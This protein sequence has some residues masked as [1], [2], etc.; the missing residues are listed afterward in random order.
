VSSLPVERPV[1]R[2]PVLLG[3]AAALMFAFAVLTLAVVNVGGA[4]LPG[5]VAFTRGLQR[6]I[7]AG[8]PAGV[9]LGLAGDAIWFLPALAA[10]ATLLARGWRAAVFLIVAGISGYLI[11]EHLLTNIVARPRPSPDLVAIYGPGDGYGYPSGT[12]VFAIAFAGCLAFV[13]DP[14]GRRNPCVARWIIAAL[15]V[16]V[17]LLVGLSRVYVGAHWLS[18]VVAGGLLGAAWLLVLLSAYRQYT[19]SIRR[20]H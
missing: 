13:L 12:T 14:G 7:G 10:P 18:D 9:G 1:V 5:D 11:G 20:P 16:L 3:A 4:P 19:I 8:G 2:L 17:V 15:A 6:M